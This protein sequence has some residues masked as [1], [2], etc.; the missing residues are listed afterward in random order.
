MKVTRQYG[1]AYKG[2]ELG[3]RST[4]H[5]RATR[6]KS[7]FHFIFQSARQEKSYPE[8]LILQLESPTPSGRVKQG[9]FARWFLQTVVDFESAL[10]RREASAA[11]CRPA[12]STPPMGLRA[13]RVG[14]ATTS[15]PLSRATATRGLGRKDRGLLRRRAR[16]VPARSRSCG[17]HGWCLTRLHLFSR[18]TL[19]GKAGHPREAPIAA[20]MD[21]EKWTARPFKE[22]AADLKRRAPH[23]WSDWTDG[24]HRRVLSSTLFMVFT[25]IA[26]AI[27][28]AAVLSTETENALGPVEVILST[29][30]TGSMFAV[31]AGQPLCIVGVTGPVTIFTVAIFQLAEGF[32]IP[33]IPF[34]AWVQVGVAG[35]R[36]GLA[37]REQPDQENGLSARVAKLSKTVPTTVPT[38]SN[39]R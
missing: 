1:V 9:S 8:Y 6:H 14:P 34:Y 16:S 27:T 3:Q 24:F 19:V 30:I 37:G 29:T 39:L 26:P 38:H 23:Y 35:H 12:R 28:F 5:W 17:E 21:G 36:G 11:I 13:G 18:P 22:M 25:S 15:P 2:N 31:F 20:I 7:H 4:K 33:F 10:G 32:D